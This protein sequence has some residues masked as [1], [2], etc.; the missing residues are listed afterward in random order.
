MGK[1]RFGENFAQLVVNG[2]SARRHTVAS[3]IPTKSTEERTVRRTGVT[4]VETVDDVKAI[5]K[6]I[7]CLNRLG[8]RRIS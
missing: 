7:E 8:Q 4:A 1:E 6:G 3:A 2:R 5:L